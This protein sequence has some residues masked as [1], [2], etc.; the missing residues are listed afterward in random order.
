MPD[1]HQRDPESEE[2]E[3]ELNT[4]EESEESSSEGVTTDGEADS[5]EVCFSI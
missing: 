3:G 2:D 4:D 1:R 5:D